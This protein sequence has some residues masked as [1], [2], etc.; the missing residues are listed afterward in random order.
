MYIYIYVFVH[1]DCPAFPALKRQ[2]KLFSKKGA[3]ALLHNAH[4]MDYICSLPYASQAPVPN[5]SPRS[6]F[7]FISE[8]ASLESILHYSPR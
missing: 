3:P 7:H 5:K 4:A 1:T 2:T 8:G 6:G